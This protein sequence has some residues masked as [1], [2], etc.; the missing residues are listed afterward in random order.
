MSENETDNLE[1]IEKKTEMTEE[2]LKAQML[3]EFGESPSHAVVEEAVEEE[4]EVLPTELEDEHAKAILESLLFVSNKPLTVAVV[5]G[6]FHGTNIKS[7]KI[8]K[9]MSQLQ[10]EY[11]GGERGLRIEEVAG[12]FQI[13]SKKENAGWVRKLVKARPFRLSGPALEVLSI[14]AY[15]QPVIKNEIDQIRGVESGHLLRALMERNL[16]RFDG[17]SELP[18]KPMQYATTKEFLELFGLRNIKELPSL[19]EIDELIPDGIG[20]NHD[21]EKETLGVLTENLGLPTGASYSD[22]ENEL[23]TITEDLGKISTSSE[24][25]EAEKRREKERRERERAQDLRE[26]KIMGETLAETDEK[27]LAKFES[28]MDQVAQ[29]ATTVDPSA[30]EPSPSEPEPTP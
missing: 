24:F 1:P 2:E 25:F 13:R 6:V 15:K 3:A 17:K 28:R 11:E 16:V 18:G 30:L 20:E 7:D 9:L 29:S 26:R 23:L 4:L 5:R 8:R 14:V 12:G 22:S 19:S 10:T 27:W 21:V